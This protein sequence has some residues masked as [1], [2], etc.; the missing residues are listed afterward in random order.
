MN[1]KRT[2]YFIGA[3]PDGEK[4]HLVLLEAKGVG[5]FT[6]HQ[7]QSKIGGFRDIFGDGGDKY[8]GVIP[9][10]ITVSPKKPG[11]IRADGWPSWV[12]RNGEIPWIEMTI[13]DG[14]KRVTRCDEAGS[15]SAE[16]R[17]WR[18]A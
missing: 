13:P 9:H 4:S 12:L 14:L 11:R 17:W 10:F 2:L 1:G 3:Y 15:A 6:N 16:G 18:T 8:P 7:L 5:G